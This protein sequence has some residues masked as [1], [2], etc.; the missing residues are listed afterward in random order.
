MLDEPVNLGPIIN[1]DPTL[2]G[3]STAELDLQLIGAKKNLEIIKKQTQEI[4]KEGGSGKIFGSRTKVN[5]AH[6]QKAIKKY[7]DLLAKRKKLIKT[8][9]T[10]PVI[11]DPVVNRKKVSK[12]MP[13]E[14]PQKIITNEDVQLKTAEERLVKLRTKQNDAGL[15]LEFT[16]KSTGQKDA[17]LKEAD[18]A[19]EEVNSKSDDIEAGFADYINCTNGNN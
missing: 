16:N 9:K 8:T 6:L 5:K 7:N 12:E 15:P 1:A 19:L 18:E 2:N 14:S 11:T 10:E 4:I 3:T 13:S 17:T